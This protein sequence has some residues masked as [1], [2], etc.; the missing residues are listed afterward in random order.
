MNPTDRDHVA[1]NRCAPPSVPRHRCRPLPGGSGRTRQTTP[2]PHMTR[3]GESR[4]PSAEAATERPPKTSPSHGDPADGECMCKPAAGSQT[5]ERSPH[6]TTASPTSRSPEAHSIPTTARG[7]RP[8]GRGSPNATR[9]TRPGKRG[10]PNA[11]RPGRQPHKGATRSAHP[12]PH[13]PATHRC[14]P[15]RGGPCPRHAVRDPQPVACRPRPAATD[16]LDNGPIRRRQPHHERPQGAPPTSHTARTRHPG[17]NPSRG[18]PRPSPPA[19]RY[20]RRT[21]AWRPRPP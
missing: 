21:N 17:R 9:E 8:G 15:P 6:P 16:P 4:M 11:A 14:A 12:A 19:T 18:G 3:G 7:A 5:V 20:P 13:S 10:S 2:A 1:A